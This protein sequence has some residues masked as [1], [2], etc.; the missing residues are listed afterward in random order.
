MKTRMKPIQKTQ[1]ANSSS[2]D[3]NI[4]VEEKHYGA[5]WYI[6]REKSKFFEELYR[7]KNGKKNY[8]DGTNTCVHLQGISPNLVG[9][10]LQY[11]YTNSSKN[12]EH[13]QLELNEINDV[14]K[15][16]I[17][18]RLKDLEKSAN[19]ELKTELD[20]LDKA[21]K[22]SELH[23]NLL[24]FLYVRTTVYRTADLAKF[25]AH[26]AYTAANMECLFE[27]LKIVSCNSKKMTMRL[28]LLDILITL[29]TVSLD[30]E[31]IEVDMKGQAGVVKDLKLCT[32]KE[33][34]IQDTGIRISFSSNDGAKDCSYNETL[35]RT[36]RQLIKLSSSYK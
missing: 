28:R 35:G 17:M 16:S 31:V 34:G 4:I 5:H 15:F 14:L 10:F 8:L 26:K 23:W 6:L 22:M 9:L 27:V 21:Q 29:F 25:V 7:C 33:F 32:S 2:C 11:A 36:V 18:F 3:V 30:Q 1:E 13:F 12:D 24:Q 20:S 19:L